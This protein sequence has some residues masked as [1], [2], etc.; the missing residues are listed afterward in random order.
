MFTCCGPTTIAIMVLSDAPTN[1]IVAPG[2]AGFAIRVML[3]LYAVVSVPVGIFAACSTVRSW[4]AIR[5]RS[6]V[7][8]SC[9]SLAGV[10]L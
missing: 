2:Q 8:G 7:A 3:I 4:R 5:L 10:V 6:L 9:L 1:E